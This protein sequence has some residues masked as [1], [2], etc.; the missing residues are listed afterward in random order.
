VA[1]LIVWAM[2]LLLAGCNQLFG[3]ERLKPAPAAQGGAGAPA[4]ADEDAGS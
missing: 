2:C 3:I 1:R 4:T